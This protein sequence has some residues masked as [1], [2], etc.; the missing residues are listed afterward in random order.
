MVVLNGNTRPEANSRNDRGPVA[1]DFRLQHVQLQL[2]L[3][4][5][6]QNEL[7]QLTRDQQDPKS[8][9]YHKWLTPTEFKQ[10][11]SLAPEDTEAVTA[12]L[13]SAGFTVEV[14]NPQSIVFSGTA[15]Q[16]RS[17]FRTEIHNLDVN[18]EKHIANMSDP[19]I[20]AAL[21]PA[22]I[23]IV[24]LNDFKPKPA[25]RPRASYTPGNGALPVVPS[26]L[27]T[28][29]NLNLAFAAGYTGQGQ[30]IILLEDSDL[31]N[32]SDWYTFRTL[33]GLG[34]YPALLQTVHP[35]PATGA[36]D[37]FYPGAV[38]VPETETTIDAE[39]ASAAAPAAGIEIASCADTTTNFGGFV[40]LENLLN[41]SSAPLSIVSLS[42]G[43]SE[44]KLGSAFNAYIS[45]LYEQG[46]SEGVSIFTSAG[47]AGAAKSDQDETTA[48]HG[49]G[50][51]GFAST[52]YNVAVGGTDFGDTFAG[53]TSAYWSSTNTS[54][55]GSAISYIPEIPWN[56]SCASALIATHLGY[57]TTYGVN[58]LCN[59]V[60][61]NSPLLTTEAGGGGPSGCATGAPAGT[62]VVGGSCTGYAKPYWQSILG[63][64]NDGVRD[65]PDVSL[66]AAVG[67]WNH[68]YVTCWSDLTYG[69]SLCNGPPSGWSG[70]GGTSFAAP[71]MAGIQALIDQKTG[72]LQGN[73]TPIYYALAAKEYGANGSSICNSTLGNRAD[74]SCTFY[75]VTQGDMDVNCTGS[76]NCYTPSGTNGVLSVSSSS[77]QPAF[78]ATVG[79]DFAT[80]IGTVNAYNLLNNWPQS[81]IT[82]STG[83]PQ[84]GV[85]STQFTAPLVAKVTDA[86]GNGVSGI[87]VT[88]RAPAS[89][90][91]GTFAGGGDTATTDSSGMATSPFFT[92]NGTTGS[93]T[94]I[95][96]A[97]DIVGAANFALTNTLSTPASVS[98]VSGTQQ[99]TMVS[100]AFSLPLIAVVKDANGDAMSNITVT[101]TVQPGGTGAGATF[102]GGGSTAA[103]DAHGQASVS[104]IANS[105]AGTFNVTATVAS[106]STPASFSLSNTLNSPWRASAASGSNQSV[107]ITATFAAPFTL[108]V[109]D[110]LSHPVSGAFVTFAAPAVGPSGTFTNGTTSDSEMTDSNGNATSTLFTANLMASF[111]YV[112]ASAGG[113][114][115]ADYYLNNTPGTPVSAMATNGSEQIT[116]INSD[117]PQPLIA[118]IR[119][120]GGNVVTS[121]AQV[122]FTVFASPSGAGATVGGRTSWTATTD[123]FGKV[124]AYPVLANSTPGSYVVT[125]IAGPIGDGNLNAEIASFFLTN[126]G[127]NLINT[128]TGTVQVTRGGSTTITVN[129][130]TNP[131]GVTLG[132]P[133][134]LT[135]S[136]SSGLTC[137]ANPASLHVGRSGG[138]A[139]ITIN[140]AAV[141]H[142]VPLQYGPPIAP[143]FSTWILAGWFAALSLFVL[144]WIAQL[145]GLAGRRRLPA[146][147]ALAL[148]ATL[149]TGLVSCSGGNSNSSTATSGAS[150][151]PGS[152]TVSARGDGLSN[153]VTIPVN[154]N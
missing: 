11:F 85:I 45:A 21:A 32:T 145:R 39:W 91:S 111:Y 136:G 26:D 102:G 54:T 41:L 151:G 65:I 33:L 148:L 117:F 140:A 60:A 150:T 19:Q 147:L 123:L 40:A 73:P 77:Y 152:V 44:A 121:G 106:V 22:I 125:A 101:F 116:V 63:N 30:T 66:F 24:S 138:T 9:N 129:V 61:S 107:A 38:P 35:F 62:G 70:F 10:R 105:M 25:S 53:S 3:P 110:T 64:P 76:I 137:T 51:S 52:P 93:Y 86:N 103:T 23:G 34:S 126:L 135:C 130:G 42:Y 6:K 46:A 132:Q 13:Q 127:L 141:S 124:T 1:G 79:W 88:F 27:A 69:G 28:I 149:A 31:Y 56:D 83:T 153:A 12:W 119:D 59:S 114:N 67:Y 143:K 57:A 16:V 109:V 97:P 68:Y 82:A 139:T 18:G 92:A 55:Y 154:V 118:T 5:E 94:V 104:I 8:P 81:G 48:T 89:G 108:T 146:L 47:D 37:C 142:F 58:G 71:I 133:V 80:G 2:R 75:D 7:D 17:A 15:G 144:S 131:A 128:A 99:S 74:S 43:V 49:I 36:L 95:A 112:Q 14:I 100:T 87:T 20:P 115:L 50:I 90:A 96:T 4:P 122:T 98:V 78:T 134:T 120:K 113:N 84:T 72:E 29:Y